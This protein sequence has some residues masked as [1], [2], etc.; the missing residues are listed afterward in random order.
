MVVGSGLTTVTDTSPE[1]FFRPVTAA[2]SASEIFWM[3]ADLFRPVP[4]SRAPAFCAKKT[5]SVGG[6]LHGRGQPGEV[7]GR[8]MLALPGYRL[9]EQG[10]DRG[11]R[12][13]G[14]RRIRADHVVELVVVDVEGPLGQGLDGRAGRR[15]ELEARKLR[16]RPR[17]AR[18]A[19]T[20]VALDWDGGGT[21]GSTAKLPGSITWAWAGTSARGRTPGP[22]KSAE[23]GWT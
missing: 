23:A 3:M 1:A 20:V 2:T 11:A 6:Y 8:G 17:A 5:S 13:H 14:Q 9:V 19:R 15:E 4:A 22:Y 16:R 12:D 21:A 7:V 18:P 10:I